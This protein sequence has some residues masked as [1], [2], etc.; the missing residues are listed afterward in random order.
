M[1]TITQAKGILEHLGYSVA[2]QAQIKND[3]ASV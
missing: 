2:V 3:K 1:L